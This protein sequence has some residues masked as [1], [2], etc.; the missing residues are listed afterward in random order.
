MMS[1]NQLLCQMP[2]NLLKCKCNQMAVSLYIRLSR[3]FLCK[4]TISMLVQALGDK[5]GVHITCKLGVINV[6]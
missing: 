6:N 2:K 3:E 5:A 1:L 4:V